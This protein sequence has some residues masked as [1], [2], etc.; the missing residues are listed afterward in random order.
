MLVAS[1]RVVH[2]TF[3]VSQA[4]GGHSCGVPSAYVGKGMFF[5]P[6]V[7]KNFPTVLD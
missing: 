4:T 6:K 1:L 5:L 3:V 2:V 7:K